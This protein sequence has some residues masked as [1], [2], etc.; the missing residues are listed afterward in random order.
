MFVC[1]HA[2][3]YV[4]MCVC[5]RRICTHTHKCIHADKCRVSG[6]IGSRWSVES[7][8]QGSGVRGF[9][10]YRR[11]CGFGLIPGSRRLVPGFRA[12]DLESLLG[13]E[14]HFCFV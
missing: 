7:R 3:M 1:M 10:V 9:R 2:W 8:F 11:E 14:V 5:A 13:G 6:V 4:C 12:A